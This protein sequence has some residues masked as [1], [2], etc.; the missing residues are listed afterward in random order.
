LRYKVYSVGRFNPVFSLQGN[1]SPMG[2]VVFFRLQAILVT[3]II[4]VF[5]VFSPPALSQETEAGEG[6]SILIESTI[7]S[8]VDASTAVT[9]EHVTI[10]IDEL[11]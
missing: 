9:I 1:R 10:P 8:G 4:S 11:E 7:T 2:K 5:A 6:E 3:G